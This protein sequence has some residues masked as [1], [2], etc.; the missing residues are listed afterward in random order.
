MFDLSIIFTLGQYCYYINGRNKIIRLMNKQI[1]ALD[2]VV[3]M[4]ISSINCIVNN[5]AKQNRFLLHRCESDRL[6]RT[7]VAARE[8]PSSCE[9]NTRKHQSCE[10]HRKSL[11]KIFLRSKH[12]YWNSKFIATKSNSTRLYYKPDE[13]F[14]IPNISVQ[15]SAETSTC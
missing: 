6:L 14:Y 4:I 13:Q 12:I 5:D 9:N 1:G 7:N 8:F 15:H 3:F 2:S 11:R 10:N